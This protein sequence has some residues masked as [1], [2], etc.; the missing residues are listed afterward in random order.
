MALAAPF[1]ACLL[2]LMAYNYARFGSPLQVG[3]SYQLS[4]YDPK[5]I[6]FGKLSYLL[7]NLWYYGI[8]PPRPTILF[9]FLLLTPAPLTYP[10]SPPA[11]YA[12]P[13]VTGG[14]LT[15]TP[16]LL[17][18]FVLPWLHRRRPALMGALARPLLVACAAGLLALAFLSYEFFNTTERYEVDFSGVFLFAALAA[19]FALSAGPPGRRRRSIRALGAVL[20]LWG[21]LTGV[22]ISFTGYENL[23]S[24]THPGTW[25]T[26]E[27]VTAP[28]STVMAVLA[29]H[30]ILAGV[31]A[32]NQA[33][34]SPVSLTSIGR[35]VESFWL[36]VGTSARL[37]IVSPDQRVAAIVATME[38]GAELRRGATLSVR[39]ADASRAPREYSIDGGGPLRLPIELKRGLNRLVLTPVAT[40]TNTPNPAVASTQQLLVVPSLTIVGSY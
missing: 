31:Q 23:L 25:N 40:A 27:S 13:E 35:G 14:L 37:T 9:P 39:I 16:L 28:I 4:G 3:Q 12:T 20:A 8:S 5:T 21:C 26:L 18:A 30:P 2:L 22:A 1:G 32:A 7:P 24:K 10:F 11:G 38:P 6:H 29:G 34:L 33:E 15:M 17:F 19:W 36:T